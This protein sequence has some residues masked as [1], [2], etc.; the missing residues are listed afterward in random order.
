MA[1]VMRFDLS[2][3]DVLKIWT[4]SLHL[5]ASVRR[6]TG[7]SQNAPRIIVMANWLP[8]EPMRSFRPGVSMIRLFS[9]ERK[10]AKRLAIIAVMSADH[11]K[12]SSLTEARHTPPMTGI[13]ESHLALL[14]VLPYRVTPSSAAKAGSAALTICV[15]DTAPAPI[16]KTDDA[17]A[18]AKQSAS[19][20]SFLMSATVTVGA[21]RASGASHRKRPY[22][23]PITSCR[24]A[25]VI[26][27]PVLPPAA[28]SASLLLRV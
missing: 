13:S 10:A 5:L 17:C 2:G 23:E 22:T 4:N 7:S 1:D 18:P 28:L 6:K 24:N 25:T 14:T 12:S 21:L 19:G 15:N 20:S 26:G 27:K 9:L 11:A 16:E 3:I 8:T